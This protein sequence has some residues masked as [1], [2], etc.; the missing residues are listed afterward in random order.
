MGPVIRG[1]ILIVERAGGRESVPSV[2][3]N[4]VSNNAFEH[5]SLVTYEL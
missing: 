3:C 1:G 2:I 5:S 4:C